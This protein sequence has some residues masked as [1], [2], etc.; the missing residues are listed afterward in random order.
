MGDGGWGK[1]KGKGKGFYIV[2][3]SWEGSWGTLDGVDKLLSHCD[4]SLR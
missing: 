3:G 4:L 2:A 1:G